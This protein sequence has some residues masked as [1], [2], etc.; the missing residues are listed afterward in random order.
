MCVQRLYDFRILEFLKVNC[1]GKY[2]VRF[3]T[4]SVLLL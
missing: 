3:E 1:S 2:S 4:E